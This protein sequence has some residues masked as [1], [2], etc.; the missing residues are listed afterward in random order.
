M[1]GYT[2]HNGLFYQTQQ[3]IESFDLSELFSETSGNKKTLYFFTESGNAYSVY[4]KGGIWF[5]KNKSDQDQGHL[6]DHERSLSGVNCPKILTR[7]QK[8]RYYTTE[9][10]PLWSTKVAQIYVIDLSKSS[11]ERPT[12]FQF[13][14]PERLPLVLG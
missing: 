14:I 4:K 10:Y 11:K 7:G 6:I 2:L 1:N 13:Y 8:F 3:H 9:G 5:V 12:G